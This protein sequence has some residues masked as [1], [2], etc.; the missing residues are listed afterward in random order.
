MS[1]WPSGTAIDSEDT[2]EFSAK[3]GA[4]PMVETYPLDQVN[5]AYEQMIS[6]KAKFRV[7]LTMDKEQD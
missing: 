4:M 1:G 3:S 7:V 2:P 5:E 6:N